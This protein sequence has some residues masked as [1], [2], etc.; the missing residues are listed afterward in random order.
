MRFFRTGLVL[1]VLVALV[2]AVPG[3]ATETEDSWAFDGGG[4]GHGVGMSQYG[5]YGMAKYDNAT[6]EEILT[7]FY[8]DVAVEPFDPG[9]WIFGAEALWVGLEESV[10]SVTLQAIGGEAEACQ[11]DSPCFPMV[12]PQPEDPIQDW[13]FEVND[14]D[15]S[16]CRFRFGTT[17]QGGT[18][19]PWG[20]CEA[21]ITW[22]DDGGTTRLKVNTREYAHGTLRLRAATS[23]FHV[24][25]SVGLENYLHGLGEMPSSWGIDGMEALKAQA[26]IARGYAIATAIARGGNDGS[27]RLSSCGCHIRDDSRDQ[28]YSGWSKENETVNG[29]N[30]GQKYWKPAVVETAGLVVT[31]EGDIISAYYSSSTGG[32]TEDNEDVWGGEPRP[33]LR[34]VE[35][36][37]GA[38]PDLNPLARWTVYVTPSDL[39]AALGWDEVVSAAKLDGPPGTVIRF[40]GVDNGQE[41]TVDKSGSE[42][43]AIL[44]TFGFRADGATVRTSPY[45]LAVTSPYHFTDITTSVHRDDIVY[46][47]RRGITKGCNPPDNTLYCPD[48]SVTRGQMAAFLVRA[49]GLPSTDRDFFTDDEGNVFENDINRLAAA[50]IT[51]G[52]NPPDN[53]RYCPDDSVTRGQMAAFLNRALGELLVPGDPVE[54]V[55][56]NGSVFEANIEW[57][58]ATG[59]TKGCNPPA[60]DRYCPTEPVIRAQMASFLARA[61]RLAEG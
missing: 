21:S 48:E 44:G 12:P 43:R 1:A 56:D 14:E 3:L 4:W 47:W 38:D 11:T 15:P 5:A 13:R 29:T 33:W 61:L 32:H 18:S 37:W 35:D 24:V 9:H 46:I 7:H 8:T 50:G 57:L 23:A 17:D 27:D 53:T 58:G 30:Y 10:T 54:F 40:S 39:A 42:V 49:L 2:P 31:Y 22:T 16:Q 34:S 59:V 26:I 55:D 45:I 52:C 36:P 28:V 51:K 25:L 60:N 19:T 6:A 41:V 20:S